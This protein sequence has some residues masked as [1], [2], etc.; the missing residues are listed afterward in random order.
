[1]ITE[2]TKRFRIIWTDDGVQSYAEEDGTVTATSKNCFETDDFNEFANKL[3]EFGVN[4]D[5]YEEFEESK[6]QEEL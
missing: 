5:S 6:E 3:K 4:F 1:M 2:M